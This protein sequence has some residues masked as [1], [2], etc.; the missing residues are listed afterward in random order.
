MSS[1]LFIPFSQQEYWSGS[2]FPPP[3][4]H[5]DSGIKPRSPSL[6]PDSLPLPFEQPGNLLRELPMVIFESILATLY[7]LCERWCPVPLFP[8]PVPLGIAGALLLL[9][10]P[11]G[12][13]GL[14]AVLLRLGSPGSQCPQQLM[15]EK[16][17]GGPGSQVPLPYLRASYL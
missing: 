6:Q 16:V 15:E 7:H 11:P 10:L 4:D 17:E 14:W 8:S 3:G 5:P 9:A 1:C 12:A 2:A 13:P